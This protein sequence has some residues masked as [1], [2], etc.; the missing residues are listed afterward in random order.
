[1][2]HTALGNLVPMYVPLFHSSLSYSLTLCYKR[3][4]E[5]KSLT[6]YSQDLIFTVIDC[7]VERTNELIKCDL[8]NCS[9]KSLAADNGNHL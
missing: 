5:N 7:K 3:A 9:F 8:Y 2:C 4:G 6:K 1:M